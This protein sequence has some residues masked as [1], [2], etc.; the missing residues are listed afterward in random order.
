[1]ISSIA[2]ISENNVIDEKENALV[3]LLFMKNEELYG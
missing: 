2:E 3:Y 1:M